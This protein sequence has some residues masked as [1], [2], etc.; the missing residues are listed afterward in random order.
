MCTL[1]HV[2]RHH[3][4]G[5]VIAADPQNKFQQ[6]TTKIIANS[7]DLKLGVTIVEEVIIPD[8]IATLRKLKFLRG[9]AGAQIFCSRH[10]IGDVSMIP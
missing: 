8:L 5:Q 9:Y 4:F 7:I 3:L 6:K 10:L 1:H 2:H